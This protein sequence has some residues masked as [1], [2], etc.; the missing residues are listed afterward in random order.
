MDL[1]YV[2]ILFVVFLCTPPLA[3]P[4]KCNKIKFKIDRLDEVFDSTFSVLKGRFWK[5]KLMKSGV[6][7]LNIST[8]K[9]SVE[10]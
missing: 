5:R 3:H 7:N 1:N 6:E 10:L 2:V 4:L 8:I 9:K